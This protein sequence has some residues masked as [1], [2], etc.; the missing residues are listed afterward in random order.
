MVRN[1]IRRIIGDYP[2]DFEVEDIYEIDVDE[3]ELYKKKLL[4][5]KEWVESELKEIENNK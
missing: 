4:N 3:D 5:I 2:E 1:E